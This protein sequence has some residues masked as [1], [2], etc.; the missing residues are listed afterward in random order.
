MF[1]WGTQVKWRLAKS[2]GSCVCSTSKL[3]HLGRQ[4]AHGSFDCAYPTLSGG[5]RVQSEAQDRQSW[6]GCPSGLQGG[7]G[8]LVLRLWDTQALVDAVEEL[9]MEWHPSLLSPPP[10]GLDLENQK[11]GELRMVAGSWLDP[12]RRVFGSLAGCWLGLGLVAGCCGW[13]CREAFY[14][15]LDSSSWSKG[16]LHGSPWQIL[17][18]RDR[19]SM[20]SRH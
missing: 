16:L 20:V 10:L 8:H 18:E 14:W 12:S 13:E 2:T 3:S 19:Q 1:C 7:W 4:D 11:R 6:H 17:M 5:D 9:R 15:R